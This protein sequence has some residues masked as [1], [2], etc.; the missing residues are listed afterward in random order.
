[1]SWVDV[2][3]IVAVDSRSIGELLASAMVRDAEIVVVVTTDRVLTR[4]SARSLC[5]A[6]EDLCRRAA[7]PE[8][9]REFGLF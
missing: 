3:G 4:L 5:T 7:P 9:S 2:A 8:G 1:L 6:Q